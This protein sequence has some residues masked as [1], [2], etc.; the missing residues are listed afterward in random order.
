MD[1]DLRSIAAARRAA[2]T[3]WDAYRRF[4]GTDPAAIDEMV[5]AMAR[6]IEPEAARLGQL[7]VDETGY[8]NVPDKR[9]KN[10]FAMMNLLGDVFTNYDSIEEAEQHFNTSAPA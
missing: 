9:I 3:A 2:D 6:A 4:L 7:A 8:G 1:A 5:D 10:L